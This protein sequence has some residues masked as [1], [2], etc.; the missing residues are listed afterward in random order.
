MDRLALPTVTLCAVT[1]VN[2]EATV[3]ALR[4][5][6]RQ[7]KFCDALLLTDRE[8]GDLPAE[9]R[10]VPIRP[11]ESGRAY[12]HFMLCQLAEHIESDHCLVVQWDGFVADPAQWDDRFLDYDFIGAPW[13]Q[14]SDGHDV[15]NGGFSLRSRKLL[16]ACRSPDFAVSHPEDVAI[17]RINRNFLEREH[18]I[19]FA[20]RGT[21]ARF[22]F[23]RSRADQPSFGFH[24]VFNMV[25][26][27][28]EE[29]FWELYET[30]DD[31][32]TIFTDYR[33]LMRQAGSGS[34]GLRRRTRLT[35]DGAR[36]LIQGLAG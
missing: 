25:E 32:T 4:S 23:E 29:R 1:S 9:I 26:V 17:G 15:G 8:V 12:S 20:D 30:L 22:S 31:R 14:F 18:G 10:K 33:L 27:L 6:L 13:P 28:G 36:R 35:I 3:A 11:I 21:A 16:E 7:I 24:G 5:C 2:V 34:N 19:R